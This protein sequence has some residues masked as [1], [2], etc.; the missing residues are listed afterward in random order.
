MG[1]AENGEVSVFVLGM[2]MDEF[3][4]ALFGCQELRLNELLHAT[5]SWDG[6][7]DDFF[8]AARTSIQ[9]QNAIR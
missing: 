7:F 5:R 2:W 6:H 1:H 3:L 4:H 9:H 8:D